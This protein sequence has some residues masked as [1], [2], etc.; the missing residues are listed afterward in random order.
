ME[1]QSITVKVAENGIYVNRREDVKRRCI[2]K[3]T[4]AIIRPDFHQEG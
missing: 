1:Y 2:H 3:F 4:D